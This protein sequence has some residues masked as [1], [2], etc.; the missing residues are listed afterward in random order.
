MKTFSNQETL[1]SMCVR[2]NIPEI[3]PQLDLKVM[4][5]REKEKVI[6]KGTGIFNLFDEYPLR[7]S[8]YYLPLG[9]IMKLHNHPKM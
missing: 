7:I 2:E 4:G 3:L 5:L 1:K 9:E 8:I 6:T